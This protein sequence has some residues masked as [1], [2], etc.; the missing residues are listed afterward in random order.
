MNTPDFLKS[1][2]TSFA[3]RVKA[4]VEDVPELPNFSDS[5]S[6][7]RENSESATPEG[8]MRT[9]YYLAYKTEACEC[10][11]LNYRDHARDRLS[12]RCARYAG[13]A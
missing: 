10:L 13:S 6:A 4:L 8:D 9:A 2:R 11:K 5:H 7:L 1:A 3:A 12:A